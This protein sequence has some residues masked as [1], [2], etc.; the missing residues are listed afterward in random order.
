[1]KERLWSVHRGFSLLFPLLRHGLS[2][3]CSPVVNMLQH[4][5]STGCREYLLQHLEHFLL[6]LLWSW[7]S[8]CYFSLFFLHPLLSVQCF[9]PFLKRAFTEATPS[10]L[11]GS[12]LTCGR[13]LAAG[14]LDRWPVQGA[15]LLSEATS[16][17]SP[18]LP[19]PCHVHP[20]KSSITFQPICDYRLFTLNVSHRAPYCLLLLPSKTLII[21]S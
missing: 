21:G 7:C 19:K 18:H 5:F 16:A 20:W 9:L 12:A 13:S 10:S 4:R 3:G 1:M 2:A 8:L 17:V 14:W 15:D 11:M 6:L